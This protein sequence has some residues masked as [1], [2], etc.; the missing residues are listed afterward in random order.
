MSTNVFVTV[1]DIAKLVKATIELPGP[2]NLGGKI[3]L[4]MSHGSAPNPKPM[5][6]KKTI[7]AVN[8][9]HLKLTIS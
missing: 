3:S 5:A 8:G 2:L 1:N 6:A 7:I 9:I 4:D